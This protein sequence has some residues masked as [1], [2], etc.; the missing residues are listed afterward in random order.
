MAKM[1]TKR[2]D[3]LRNHIK[4]AYLQQNANQVSG[5]TKGVQYL[6]HL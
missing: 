6:P 5:L 1:N 4:K 3:M 2:F